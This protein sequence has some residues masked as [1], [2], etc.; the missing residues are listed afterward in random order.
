MIC[1]T[2]ESPKNNQNQISLDFQSLKKKSSPLRKTP[3]GS[4]AAKMRE[5]IEGSRSG[6]NNVWMG[7]QVAQQVFMANDAQKF[8]YQQ[9]NM[10]IVPDGLD[11][12]MSAAVGQNRGLSANMAANPRR[13]FHGMM[14]N[15]KLHKMARPYIMS[16]KAGH[17]KIKY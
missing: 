11:R 7:G 13:N 15:A 9:Q 10:T 3:D 2:L 17:A 8:R 12:G 14:P 1:T 4:A 16:A 5:K 6:N